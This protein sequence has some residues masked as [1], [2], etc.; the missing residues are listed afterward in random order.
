MFNY[1]CSLLDLGLVI[2]NFFDA[3]SEGD[4]MRNVRCWKFM[5]PYLK[6]DGARSRKYSLEA[7]YLLCQIYAI[8]SPRDAHRLI[9]NRFCKKKACS[10]GN[11]PLDL[12][13]EHFNNLLKNVVQNLGP[14]STNQK[15]IDRYCKA[16]TV[17]KQL[18]EN[19][20]ACCK[21]I[22][23]SGKHVE[24]NLTN[25]LKKILHELIDQKALRV[26]PGRKYDGFLN[27]PPTLLAGFDVHDM[28][29]WIQDHKKLVKNHKA[30]R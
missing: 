20:D 13:L 14:N 10:G 24:A 2:V 15:V 25:D 12:A 18:L 4:G 1:Q 22:R 17:I 23:R 19:F 8:L 16:L 5:L 6:Q 3:I 29:K 28:Y 9:W 11:I 27:V 30:G 21:E 7:L 26:T